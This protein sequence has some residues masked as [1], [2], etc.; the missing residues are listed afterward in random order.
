M[1]ERLTRRT[2]LK[3]AAL[4]A[5]SASLTSGE[6]PRP[7]IVDTHTHFYNPQR[8]EGVPWPA[9]DDKFLYRPV[10]PAEYKELTKPHGVVGTVVVEASPRPD[11]NQWILDLAAKDPFLLGLVGNL[12]PGSKEFTDHFPKLI[13]Q[14]KF[15]G[16]RV[17]AGPLATG[18]DKPEFLTDLKKLCD[19]ERQLDVNG[20]P[21]LLPLV[22]KLATKLPDLRIVI[23]HLANVRID[24]PLLDPTW[25][26]DLNAA[27]KH[28]H[29]YLKV[30]ALV[31]GAAQGNRTAPTDPAYYKP[32]LNAAFEVFG[33]RRV[34]YGSNWPVSARFGN[35]AVVQQIVQTYARDKGN[36]VADRFFHHNAKAAYRWPG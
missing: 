30:S 5:C 25:F 8:P 15:L 20:R 1:T 19:A 36:E 28:P 14:P 35:Y 3:A 18:L 17:N 24:G 16:I 2:W 12:A 33:D 10:L 23:N 27:A 4:T 6:E 9:P 31:E 22:S 34:I 21:D 29:V 26:Q 13:A 11:D 32:T 7:G